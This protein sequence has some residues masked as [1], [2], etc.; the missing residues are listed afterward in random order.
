MKQCLICGESRIVDGAHLIPKRFIESLEA[1]KDV[2][3][4]LDETIPLC[5]THHRLFDLWRL[6]DSEK[7]VIEPLLRPKLEML[8]ILYTGIEPNASGVE[9]KLL[10]RKRDIMRWFTLAE[11]CFYGKQKSQHN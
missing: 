7:K 9:S 3:A 6:N 4:H 2:L 5:P 11:R 8:V 10:R 1:D